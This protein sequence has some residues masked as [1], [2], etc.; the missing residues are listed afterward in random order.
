MAADF[1]GIEKAEK[2]WLRNSSALNFEDSVTRQTGSEEIT[3][4]RK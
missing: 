3:Q 4:L 2:L 1:G